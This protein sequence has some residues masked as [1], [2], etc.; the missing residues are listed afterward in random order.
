MHEGARENSFAAS[1]TQVNE[2]ATR[3]VKSIVPAVWILVFPFGLN[4]LEDLEERLK[5]YLSISQLD[6]F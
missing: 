5:L 1:M 6:V 4:P 3:V 2:G